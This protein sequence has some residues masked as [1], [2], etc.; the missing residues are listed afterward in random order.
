MPHRIALILATGLL[1][2]CAGPHEPEPAYQPAS[3]PA[4]PATQPVAQVLHPC[5]DG[6][7]GGVLINGVC[8]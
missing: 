3:G 6:G 5:D 4:A 7:D 1:L 8:L 2:A